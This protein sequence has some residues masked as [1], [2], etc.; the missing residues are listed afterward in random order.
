[1]EV[2][3]QRSNEATGKKASPGDEDKLPLYNKKN[4]DSYLS[5]SVYYNALFLE[6][7]HLCFQQF[8]R[9]VYPAFNGTQRLIEHFSNLMVLE[10]VEVQQ[11]GI[12]EY[13]G[14]VVY[15]VLNVFQPQVTLRF[16]GSYCLVMIEQEIVGRTIEYRVLFSFSAVIIDKDIPHYGVQPRFNVGTNIV[17]ILIGQRPE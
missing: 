3:R 13:F 5:G 17:L 6:A 9:K 10:P 4:P 2:T 8:A 7:M 15:G 16:I 1:M 12:P 11:E 14:Q